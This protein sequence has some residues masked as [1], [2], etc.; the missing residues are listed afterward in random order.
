MG[1]HYKSRMHP[2]KFGLYDLSW[3]ERS[4]RHHTSLR[5][6]ANIVGPSN[7]KSD[8]A[9]ADWDLLHWR[10]VCRVPLLFLQD[11]Y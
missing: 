3:N 7:G 4:N 2:N 8:E 11:N 6:S 1:S 10:L 5:P 9:P